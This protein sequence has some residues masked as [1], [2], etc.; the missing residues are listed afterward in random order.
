[1]RWSPRPWQAVDQ[2]RL[3]Q[4]RPDHRAGPPELGDSR[5]CGW[6][7]E[8]VR[9]VSQ[10]AALQKSR[11]KLPHARSCKKK[12][13]ARWPSSIAN[14]ELLSIAWQ[15]GARC[16]PIPADMDAV[17]AAAS[18]SG[19]LPPLTPELASVFRLPADTSPIEWKAAWEGNWEHSVSGVNYGKIFGALASPH[20]KH[21]CRERIS[22]RMPSSQR[23]NDFLLCGRRSNLWQNSRFDSWLS[24]TPNLGGHLCATFQARKA[25]ATPAARPAVAQ[26]FAN[27]AQRSAA[28]GEAVAEKMK[29]GLSY[30]AA[31]NAVER[32]QAHLF[33]GM[34]Q[35]AIT[36]PH[37]RKPITL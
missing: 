30:G 17:R 12:L 27:A 35:V 25:E 28:V 1:M 32:E 26:T 19:G 11:I 36:M 24:I 31:F 21:H 13:R 16:F 2:L 29:T 15:R 7:D 22:T 4:R 5:L 20:T 3:Q 8:G 33:A 9:P 34:N 10:R 23:R 37:R 6:Q 14:T 18:G